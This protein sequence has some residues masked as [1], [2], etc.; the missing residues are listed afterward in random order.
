MSRENI[1]NNLK[2]WLLGASFPRIG[3]RR[4]PHSGWYEDDY[5]DSIKMVMGLIVL[6][7]F[8]HPFITT[9][10]A[11]TAEKENQ[12]KVSKLTNFDTI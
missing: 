10:K 4:F 2:D 6:F 9:V 3:M 11:I 5:L 8:L 1:K 7:S 12:I